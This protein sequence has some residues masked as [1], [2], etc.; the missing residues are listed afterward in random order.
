MEIIPPLSCF[1]PSAHYVRKSTE[2][3]QYSP[4]TSLRSSVQ[5]AAAQNMEIVKEYS[6]HGRSGLNMSGRDGLNQPMS[7]VEHKRADFTSLLV[8][9][10][11][12]C[13]SSGM[14]CLLRKGVGTIY[15]LGRRP[16]Q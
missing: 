7:D 5:Y 4:E 6:D 3:Q 13:N 9:G 15:R 12:R 8:Y 11:S 2:H 16:M 14:R 10:G 1:V